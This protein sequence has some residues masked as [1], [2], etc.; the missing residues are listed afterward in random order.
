VEQ[1]DISLPNVF[2]V[3]FNEIDV[4]SFFRVK[5]ISGR[6]LLNYEVNVLQI[7]GMPGGH[8]QSKR[9]PSRPITID[10]IFMCKDEEELLKRLEELNGIFYTDKPVPLIF[11][12]EP[13]RTY[14]A[15][16]TG[17]SEKGE[18][19]GTYRATLSFTCPDP[20]KYGE[21]QFM[22]FT[23]DT[24]KPF[25]QGTYETFPRIEATFESAASEFK[26]EQIQTGKYVRVVRDFIAGDV[27]VIDYSTGKITLNGI[28]S[29][30]V[31]RWAESE[32]YSLKP[33]VQSITI[34][35]T[36]RAKTKMFW[37]PRWL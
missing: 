21:E 22:D 20:L 19:K 10:A 14:Y 25:I 4:T 29:M 9:L 8:P 5:S 24:I 2:K 13:D 37:N 15:T 27:L 31:L 28:L 35:P 16:Y 36:N 17:A 3:W 6:G 33:G 23:S 34:S 12:D 32:Y 26:I 30:T 11:S 7:P 18:W 1:L